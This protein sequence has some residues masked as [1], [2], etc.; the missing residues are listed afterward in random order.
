MTPW[1]S[2]PQLQ[3]DAFSKDKVQILRH[4]KTCEWIRTRILDQNPG[5]VARRKRTAQHMTPITSSNSSPGIVIIFGNGTTRK[6]P[7][8]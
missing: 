3:Y 2:I 5:P 4:P 1:S 7:S 8:S 6:T